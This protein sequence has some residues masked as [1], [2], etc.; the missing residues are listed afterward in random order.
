M[1][2]GRFKYYV[3]LVKPENWTP[4]GRDVADIEIEKYAY[5]PPTFDDGE[6]L[7]QAEFDSKFD[8]KY[9]VDEPSSLLSY[10]QDITLTPTAH[11]VGVDTTGGPV[12]VTLPASVSLASGK[13]LVIKDE[14]GSAGVNNITIATSNGALIDGSSSIKLVSNYGAINLYY[15][16][17]GW[18]IY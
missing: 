5:V 9:K 8:D 3:P 13:Q 12:T 16:G 15:N 10:S 1:G 4:P 11:F 14:G 6:A 7:T 2:R 18:H 17:S